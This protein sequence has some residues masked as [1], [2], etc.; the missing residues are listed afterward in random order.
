MRSSAGRS[1]CAPRDVAARRA[2]GG[3]GGAPSD[4]R[5]RTPALSQIPPIAV[6]IAIL[7]AHSIGTWER[8]RD[9]R[10]DESLWA[11]VVKKSPANGR[12]IMNYGLTQMRRGRYQEAR[13]LFLRAQ[14]KLPNYSFLEV[15][16]GVVNAA[17]GNPIGAEP[18]FKRAISLD[19]GQPSVHRFYA[20]F[21]V[22]Q[23]RAPEAI[24]QLRRTLDLSPGETDARHLLMAI[25]AAEGD[26]SQLHALV[27]E[28]LAIMRTDP[29]AEAYARGSAAQPAVDT[30]QGWFDLGFAFTRANRNLEAAQSYRVA[31]ARD[32][33]QADA[34]NNLGFALGKLGF[35]A[36]AAPALERA[37]QLRPTYQLARNNLAWVRGELARR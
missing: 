27:T 16:L 32:S 9:W 30:Y 21:L 3:D 6:M 2:T 4:A 36:E 15:N 29:D 25:F 26:Q 34:W 22:D 24:G 7:I 37:I 5:P 12:G 11:D 20:R 17:M 19:E 28:T 35:F 14:E 33:S 10:D 31:L 8:N 13:D 23:G 1:H 18:H